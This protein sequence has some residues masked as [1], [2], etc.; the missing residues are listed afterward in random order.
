[1]KISTIHIQET[2]TEL[3]RRTLATRARIIGT[4]TILLMVHTTLLVLLLVLFT[5]FLWLG[6]LQ[7]GIRVLFSSLAFRSRGLLFL[8]FFCDEFVVLGQLHHPI[9]E[10]V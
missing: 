7:L 10:L 3:V 5:G 1:M 8:L 4:H 9:T 2:T 6:T